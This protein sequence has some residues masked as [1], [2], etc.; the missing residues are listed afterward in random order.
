[1]AV[2]DQFAHDPQGF[3][4]VHPF[5]PTVDQSN[6]PPTV[7]TVGLRG[8]FKL[9]TATKQALGQKIFQPFTNQALAW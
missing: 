2:V 4:L 7:K 5:S 1:L 3:L 6:A 9:A 8:Q